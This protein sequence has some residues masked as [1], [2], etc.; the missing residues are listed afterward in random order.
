MFAQYQHDNIYAS[1]SISNTHCHDL[2]CSVQANEARIYYLN[3][4]G[5]LDGHLTHMQDEEV[6]AC[7][8]HIWRPSSVI[9]MSL[10]VSN[11]HA[12]NPA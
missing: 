5:C 3:L 1:Q 4:F 7:R 12:G 10:K 11:I 6:Y 2:S 9:Q 8:E